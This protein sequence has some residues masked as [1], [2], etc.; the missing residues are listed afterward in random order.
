MKRLRIIL[1]SK[2]FIVVLLL[3][4]LIRIALY[5]KEDKK[6]I[7]NINDNNFVCTILNINLENYTLDCGETIEGEI[8]AKDLNIGDIIKVKGTLEEFKENKNINL[9][10][11]KSYQ[12]NRGIF[13]KLKVKSYKKID[14]SN[15]IIIKIKKNIVNKIKN[16][17]SFN[18]LNAFV[19]GDKSKIDKNIID[20]FKNLGIIHLFSV[21]GMHISFLL[22]FMDKIYNRKTKIKE[23]TTILFLTL[24]YY[25]IRSISL[26]RCLIFLIVKS[27]NT[28]LN[29]NIKKEILLLISILLILLV[30]PES[31]YNWTCQ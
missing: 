19:L 20:A 24:Y 2:Q 22:E 31:L 7:Y 26:F 30:K 25:L 21:S 17:K 12:K 6:S 27:T 15:N 5:I 23:I 10:D 18:Y 11:Y 9:F 14:E 4:I 28:N 16:L 3:L 1:K 29:L 8:D 13:Y